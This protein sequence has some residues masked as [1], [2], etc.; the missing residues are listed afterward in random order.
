MD[1]STVI[2][3]ERREVESGET[4]ATSEQSWAFNPEMA[5]PT[6][7]PSESS[8]RS[9]VTLPSLTNC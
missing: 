7:A 1:P 9:Q 5:A 8:Q 3:T 6:A 4:A 2:G